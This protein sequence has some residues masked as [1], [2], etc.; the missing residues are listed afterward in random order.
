MIV[1]AIANR[2]AR[3]Y[4]E[5]QT[6]VHYAA[7]NDA[8]DSLKALLKIGCDMEVRDSK[9]RTPL[10]VASELGEHCVS[11]L[12]IYMYIYSLFLFFNLLTVSPLFK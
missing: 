4:G 6:V 3:T 12:C 5:E 11:D 9:Q 8:L 7:K 1:F 10:Q 2:D